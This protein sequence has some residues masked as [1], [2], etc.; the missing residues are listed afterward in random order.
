MGGEP[1]Q[2]LATVLGT[3]SKRG[4]FSARRTAAPEGLRIDV[5]G[6]GALSIPVSTAQARQLCAIARPARYGL[7]EQTLTDSRVRH[8]WEVPKSRV[9]IDKQWRDGTLTP[10][11]A[12][13][14]ADL[15][16]PEGCWLKA[17]LH[18]VLV[19]APGQ[20]FVPHQDS[21]KS[22][23][24][25]GTLS[26]IL[27]GSS[28]GGA[29]VIE[30]AGSKVT[31]RPSDKLLTFAAFYADCRHEVRPVRSGYRVVLTYN[32]ML[33]GDITGAAASVA[34]P[35]IDELSSCLEE[36]FTEESRLV[37]LLDH[38]YTP[39]GLH[40]S[41]LKGVDVVRV[42]ALSAAARAA[43]CE[44]VLALAEVHETWSCDEPYRDRYWRDEDEADDESHSSGLELGELLDGSIS[45]D[46]WVDQSGQAAQPAASWVSDAEVCAT[47]PT[48]TLT[49]YD[50]TYEGYMGN[51]GNTIDRWYRRG[52]VVVW[53]RRL[54]FVVRAQASPIWA[55]DTLAAV[56]RDGEVVR[57]RELV[58]AVA[59]FW[60]DVMST[61]VSMGSPA[62]APPTQPGL[63]Q[64]LSVARGLD[65]ARLAAM[66]LGPFGLDLLT[67]ADAPALTA[68][69][70]CY[71]E[72][73]LTGLLAAWDTGR[74]GT[75]ATAR[76]R[77]AWLAS[78]PEL[79]AALVRCG[80]D[81]VVPPVLSTCWS[82]LVAALRQAQSHTQPSLQARHLD[83]LADPIAGLLIGA[84]VGGVPELR[85]IA[86]A[87]L[88]QDDSLVRCVVRVLRRISAVAPDHRV[89][90]G[91]D[92]L[93]RH[94]GRRLEVRL[95][96]PSRGS[97]DWSINAP[98]GCGCALCV[99]LSGF[100]TDPVRQSWDWPLKEESR[101]HIH[102]RIDLHELPVRHQ[103]RRT[104]RPY[105]LVL[106]KL[107][108]LFEREEQARAEDGADLRWIREGLG[109]A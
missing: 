99:T 82:W 21:E 35:V 53:P 54:D 14:R 107:P 40:W 4:A 58:G 90:S 56:L 20:F 46:T 3:T 68:I 80:G 57:A 98:G 91:F 59:T 10:V 103:T 1:R 41:R 51:Y 81:V 106:A 17:E 72:G 109:V 67:P 42:A 36:H 66:L 32:L 9:T 13:L 11:L 69:V 92:A 49:P 18:A 39:R 93:A 61:R 88:C 87:L 86:V 84:A 52:A 5:A 76:D 45:L 63:G 12:A 22:D 27:P 16:L 100:L 78:L 30:H 108:T 38:Q 64:A 48:S 74:R 89:G 24:M 71:G 44:I 7:G 2:R 94:A 55:L 77:H 28:Q 79:C 50:S 96:Q 23:A 75:Y 47:T 105:T 97:D 65:D 95:A 37:Y 101:R 33:V 62:Y 83:E 26:L 19:Y 31:Y 15:G 25:V 60:M 34:P 85:E 102:S 104:G 29:L 43:D 73:W 6:V 8:T 70:E